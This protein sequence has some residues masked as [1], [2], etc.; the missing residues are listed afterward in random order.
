MDLS[1]LYLI[2]GDANQDRRAKAIKNILD[3]RRT[4]SNLYWGLEYGSYL[5][6]GP[7]M[8]SI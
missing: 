7:F 3:G 5:I 6:L 8:I 4:V 2:F 1:T